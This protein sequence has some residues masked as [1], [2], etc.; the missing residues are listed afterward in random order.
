M[1]KVTIYTTD[2]CPYCTKAKGILQEAKIPFVEVDLTNND[3]LRTQVSE[4]AKMKT[5]PII[6]FGEKCVGGCSDLMELQ[7]NGKLNEALA[8]GE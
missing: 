2:W 4:K 8:A 6:F 1:T 3:E 5:V 7:K